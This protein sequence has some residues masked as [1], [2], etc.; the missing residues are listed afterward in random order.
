MTKQEELNAIN[1]RCEFNKYNGIVVTDLEPERSVV[2]GE[3]RPEALNPMD[4]AHGGFVYSLCD[5]AAGVVAGQH[6]GKFVTLSSN[7]NFIRQSKGTRLRCEG[8]LVKSGRT[9]SVVETIVY[10]DAGRQTARGSFEIFH[11]KDK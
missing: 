4:M 1:N 10:D 8:T 6:D 5:V 3:L 11:I 7:M 9:V 2:E